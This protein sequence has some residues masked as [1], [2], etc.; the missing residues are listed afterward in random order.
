MD[1]W[2]DRRRPVPARGVGR[3]GVVVLLLLAGLAGPA[4]RGAAQF[5]AYP[6]M[7]TL[8][9][10]SSPA[11]ASFTVENHGA[12]ALEVVVYLGDYERA[13]DGGHSY[14]PFGEHEGTCAGRLR[15]FPDQLAIAP[16]GRAEVQV[17]VESGPATCWGMVFVEHRSSSS[18]GLTVAQRIAVKV[19]GQQTGLPRAGAVLG[20]VADTVDPPAVRI[21]F[22][23]QGPGALRPRGEVEIRSFDGEVV[24]VAPMAAFEVL[25]SR[26]RILR[27]PLDELALPPGRYVAVGIV[28]FDGEYLAGGQTLLEIRP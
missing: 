13:P 6:V 16:A 12:A 15:A 27:V 7:M 17:R 24:A 21:A 8:E 14:L 22:E 20:M 3:S 23:N 26:R 11:V 18:L 1:G 19:V 28:D 10:G 4:S 9:T 25:P 2:V 5:A